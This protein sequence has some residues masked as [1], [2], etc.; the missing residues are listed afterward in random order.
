MKLRLTPKAEE[1]LIEI[2]G[3]GARVFGVSQ[4]ERY[5]VDL[6]ATLSLLAER[7]FIARERFEFAPPVRVHFHNSHV[8]VY[9]VKGDLVLV[10]RILGSR[11][12]WARILAEAPEN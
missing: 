8:I 11:Q 5:Y 2:Y 12:D 9:L 3:Y 4:A 7:P 1:D 6:E 10:V